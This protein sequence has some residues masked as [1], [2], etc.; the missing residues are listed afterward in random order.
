[1]AILKLLL[2][3][4][5]A[6]KRLIY[7][8]EDGVLTTE[9]DYTLR[10][11]CNVRCLRSHGALIEVCQETRDVLQKLQDKY[12]TAT[13]CS[14]RRLKGFISNL[15][16][17]DLFYYFDEDRTS[18]VER[19]AAIGSIN[20]M[21][22]GYPWSERMY[23]K[24][25]RYYNR[26]SLQFTYIAY[27]YDG[28]KECI[29]EEDI[30]KRVCRFCGRRMPEVTFEKD[31]HAIQDALGNR[32]LFCYE[33]CDT[34]NRDLALTEDNF[35]YLMDFRRAMYNVP[36]K[37][38]FK[39]PTVVGKTFII[40]ADAQGKPELYLMEESLPAPHERQYPF[41][42]HLELKTPINNERMNKA[43]CKMVIDMLPGIELPHFKN[44][45]KWIT[46]KGELV[47]DSLPSARMAVLP[48]EQMSSQPI[49]DIFLNNRDGRSEAPYCTA[50]VWMYDIVYMFIVPFVDVDRGRYKYDINL[51]SHWKRMSAILGIQEWQTQDTS[52]YRLS[53][54]WVEWMIDLNEPN[55]HVLPS[56]DPIFEACLEVKP[57]DPDINMPAFDRDGISLDKTDS[58][59]FTPYY[60]DHLTDED[61]S[62]V[63]QHAKGPIFI[64]MPHDRKVRVSMSIDVYDTC[65]QIRFYTIGFDIT[66][67][68]ERFDDYIPIQYDQHGEVLSF[69]FHYELSEYLFTKSL[70]IAESQLCEQRKGTPFE[71]CSMTKIGDI[72]R[73]LTY[74]YY[75][76]PFA[77][78]KTYYCVSDRDIHGIDYEQLFKIVL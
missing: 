32:I 21:K 1:M 60:S 3:S 57:S 4:I 66:F 7:N 51:E 42:M 16:D 47:P 10:N 20:A 9:I 67:Q 78:G 72:D 34:C 62:D 71:K 50:V 29:G 48:R 41:I 55:I 73:I 13:G 31:A 33:E 59:L 69:A 19:R 61:L 40:K 46:S 70:E 24:I 37:G 11:K 76:V 14:I 12:D 15:K 28:L 18:V 68:I 22:S 75:H 17:G 74:A 27:G 39:T 53:I 63:F 64:L 45:V 8:D 44:T 36:R 52:E 23:N 65:D 77:D 30:T 26:M 35:R 2:Y 56:S 43:L 25:I 54:P 38:S 58:L 5:K 6:T 49:L